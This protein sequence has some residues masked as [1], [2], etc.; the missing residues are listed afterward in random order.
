MADLI[1]AFSKIE[2][3]RSISSVLVRHGH[4]VVTTCRSGSYVLN[5]TDRISSGIIICGYK[6]SDMVYSELSEDIPGSFRMIVVASRERIDEA[7]TEGVV[8]EATPISVKSLLGSIEAVEAET[9]ERRRRPAKRSTGD[10]GR[11]DAAKQLLIA[12]R[13]MTEPEAHKFLQRKSMESG[14]SLT[15]AA[16]KVMLMYSGS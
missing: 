9:Y 4:N 15:V 12:K 3:A 8:F 6:L 13:G 2:D 5:A 11:I 7:E 10:R 16:E 14:V 1:V